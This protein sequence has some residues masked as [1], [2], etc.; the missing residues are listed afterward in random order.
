MHPGQSL[1]LEVFSSFCLG[2]SQLL[3]HPACKEVVELTSLPWLFI[4]LWC[5][6]ILS[7]LLH[8][9]FLL[10]NNYL[11]FNQ[12]WCASFKFLS[13]GL[14]TIVSTRKKLGDEERAG[15]PKG[16]EEKVSQIEG[17]GL[18]FQVTAL[19]HLCCDL[20]SWPHLEVRRRL[21]QTCRQP[22]THS[23][24]QASL[25]S[26]PRETFSNVLWGGQMALSLLISGSQSSQEQAED[27]SSS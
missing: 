12:K 9:G 20:W 25:I 15:S 24:L 27:S 3:G 17:A 7:C 11:K 5:F 8:L 4:S 19:V 13:V 22:L 10:M 16:W 26:M 6:Q 1:L 14:D 21:F 2:M 18:S 23:K